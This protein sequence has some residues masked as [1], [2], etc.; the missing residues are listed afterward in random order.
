[1]E[2]QVEALVDA[3][4]ANLRGTTG[5]DQPLVPDASSD[6]LLFQGTPCFDQPLAA[7]APTPAAP[8]R[9]SSM[10][11]VPAPVVGV[12]E[13]PLVSAASSCAEPVKAEVDVQKTSEAELPFLQG[14]EVLAATVATTAISNCEAAASTAQKG[15]TDARNFVVQMLAEAKQFSDAPA[16]SCTKMQMQAS[17]E[18]IAGVEAAVQGL[19][20]TLAKLSDAKLAEISAEDARSVCEEIAQ[21]EHGT[22]AAVADARKFLAQRL[23]DAKG[24][25]ETVRG[26]ITKDLSKLQSR[27]TQCQVELAKLSKQ[28]TE[29]EVTIDTMALLT[30]AMGDPTALP[31]PA[32]NI[33]SELLQS[34]P[35]RYSTCV[36]C[37]GLGLNPYTVN[38][39]EAGESEHEELYGCEAECGTCAHVGCI[40]A[41]GPIKPKRHTRFKRYRSG[42]VEQGPGIFCPSCW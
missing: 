24:F 4:L 12:L 10:D 16:E 20:A 19:A 22:Q 41:G 8:L 28:R 37:G 11:V 3:K 36:L 23:Q 15:I 30:E 2:N 21:A 38:V 18:K 31:P 42:W 14:I 5:R 26:P 29:R 9:D 13:Q 32:A 17:G 25:S 7:G 33:A 35:E 27:L 1:M 34:E 39:E 6:A 40:E